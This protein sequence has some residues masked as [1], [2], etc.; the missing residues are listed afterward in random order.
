[1]ILSVRHNYIYVRTKKTGS[2]TIEAVLRASLGPEDVVI[3]RNFGVLKPLLKPGAEIPGRQQGS[4]AP[5][6]VAIKEIGPLLCPEFWNTAFKFTSERHPY[7]K[8]VSLAY[9]GWSR[10]EDRQRR[11]DGS[12]DRYLDDVVHRGR[13]AGFPLYSI[14][15]LLAVHDFIRVETLASDL[16]RI[17]NRLGIPVPDDLPRERADSRLDRRPAN[18]ILSDGQKQLVWR[19]CQR[20]FEILGY[21]S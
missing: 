7:E 2:T 15:G 9:M 1:M 17:G 13:Y 11:F 6:H 12:F 21:R 16:K 20:E 5:T 18:E 3:G 10:S 4:L 14:D 8:A 19:H